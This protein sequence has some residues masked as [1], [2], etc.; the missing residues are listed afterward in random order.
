[1]KTKLILI[2]GLP[3]AGRTTTVDGLKSAGID[4]CT[5]KV[6]F[7]NQY[8]NPLNAFWTWGD[9][10]VENEVVEEPYDSAKFTVRILER[11]YRLVSRILSQD[12]CVVMEG[13]PFQ[14]VIRNMLKM[15]GTEDDCREYY[16]RFVDAISYCSPHLFYLQHPNWRERIARIAESRG[17]AFRSIFFTA[18]TRTPYGREHGVDTDAKV[19]DFYEYCYSFGLSLLDTWPFDLTRLDPIALG[20]QGT[21]D[22]IVATLSQ[23]EQ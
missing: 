21:V 5:S 2:E 23:P 17:A 12:L 6:D 19:I 14:L 13:Y 9:G 7:Y 4:W 3:G 18:M 16:R 11:T 22:A 1:M 10:A 8:D 20:R 15:L